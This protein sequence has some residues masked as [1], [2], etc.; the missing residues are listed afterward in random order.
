MLIEAAP[1]KLYAKRRNLKI[2]TDT[3]NPTA[4]KMKNRFY[5]DF[6]KKRDKM[7]ILIEGVDFISRAGY[8]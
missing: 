2:L 6:G 7:I 1:K 5:Y 3:K 4:K 8:I